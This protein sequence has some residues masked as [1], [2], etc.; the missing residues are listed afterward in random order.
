MRMRRSVITCSPTAPK[1]PTKNPG[2]RDAAWSMRSIVAS[3]RLQV[4]SSASLAVRRVGGDYAG[5]PFDGDGGGDG[6]AK[7]QRLF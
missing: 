7:F 3:G 6:V 4:S 5:S 2:R 1:L